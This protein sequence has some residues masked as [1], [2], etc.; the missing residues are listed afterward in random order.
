MKAIK[1]FVTFVAISLTYLA[2]A[3]YLYWQIGDSSKGGSNTIE[4]NYALLY[5][6]NGTEK[7]ILPTNVEGGGMFGK[8]DLTL[9]TAMPEP[10]MTDIG[11]GFE[12]YSFYVELVTWN[13]ATQT[14]TV[15]GVSEAM[16]YSDLASRGHITET[17]MGITML[18]LTPWMPATHV[19]EPSSAMLLLLGAAFILLKRQKMA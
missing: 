2:S 12:N 16:T 10:A 8:D 3:E 1:L 6:D 7:I 14:E 17:D 19:P 5:A 4:F 15:V 18:E 13:D 9:T 11:F